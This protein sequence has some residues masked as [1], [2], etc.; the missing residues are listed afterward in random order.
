MTGTACRPHVVR[1][2]GPNR[3][4]RTRS[5]PCFPRLPGMPHDDETSASHPPEEEQADDG[6]GPEPRTHWQDGLARFDVTTWVMYD[7]SPQQVDPRADQL[8]DRL[9]TANRVTTWTLMAFV[10]VLV[11]P[12]MSGVPTLNPI[13]LLLIPLIMVGFIV[14]ATRKHFALRRRTGAPV[15]GD[16]QDK[17]LFDAL[18]IMIRCIDYDA[19]Q[20]W[21]ALAN[22]PTVNRTDV[23][24]SRS[25][26]NKMQ[27]TINANA[28]K[29]MLYG[30]LGAQ[31]ERR[32]WTW[33][34]DKHLREIHKITAFYSRLNLKAA[35]YDQLS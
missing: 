14:F 32:G 9:F 4:I 22:D 21:K 1:A 17:E 33:L 34:R 29:I 28:R 2:T 30:E 35:E 31:A 7:E 15:A 18:A 25:T 13:A 26:A 19:L 16:D 3:Q 8:A 6:Q 11:L 23:A 20:N 27:R 24:A 5:S 12:S 10:A